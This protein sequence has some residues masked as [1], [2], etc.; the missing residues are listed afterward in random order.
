VEQGL[1]DGQIQAIA[2]RF[3]TLADA[4]ILLRRAAFPA[5]RMPLGSPSSEAFWSEVSQLLGDGAEPGCRERLLAVARELY[6][7]EPEFADRAVGAGAERDAVEPARRVV[8]N[9]PARLVRF[10]GRDDLLAEIDTALVAAPRAALVALEGMGG[11]GKTS[12]A[13]E[14]A[15]RHADQFDIVWWVAA[16]RSELVAQQMVATSGQIWWPPPGRKRDRHW[17]DLNGP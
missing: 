9:V 7:G 2:Q 3:S 14:Y 5:S 13:V 8:W 12:L 10:V 16:E 17:A 11:V 15:Y 6:P 1:S 4:R